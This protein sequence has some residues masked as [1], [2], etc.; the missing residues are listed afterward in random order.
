MFAV[1]LSLLL[2]GLVIYLQHAP[3]NAEEQIIAEELREFGK[4]L[5]YFPMNEG[6]GETIHD[7][8]DMRNLGTFVGAKKPSWKQQWPGCRHVLEFPGEEAA[9]QLDQTYIDNFDGAHTI[10]IWAY[11]YD[12]NARDILFGSFRRG[13]STGQLNMEKHDDNDMRYFRDGTLLGVDKQT[14]Y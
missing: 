2:N 14:R 12:N 1:H 10:F 11:F 3:V 4:L 5:N 7:Y 8:G 6:G 9:V 13:A